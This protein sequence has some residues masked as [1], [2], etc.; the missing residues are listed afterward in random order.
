VVIE[1]VTL[2]AAASAAVSSF[3]RTESAG[4]SGEICGVQ[5]SDKETYCPVF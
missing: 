2:V 1:G 4:I 5:D 3:K